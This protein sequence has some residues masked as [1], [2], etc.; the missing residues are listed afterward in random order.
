MP[1]LRVLGS[2]MSI[3]RPLSPY[4]GWRFAIEERH[5]TSS[6]VAR[7]KLWDHFKSLNIQAPVRIRWIEGLYLDLIL[8]N[9][10]SRCMYVCGSFEPNEFAYLREALPEG[11]TFIDI[12]AN[13]GFYTVFAARRVGSGGAVVAV[14]PSPREYARLENN[15]AING[16]TNVKLARTALGARRGKA[17]LHVADPEHNGQNTLGDFGHAEVKAVDHVQ[18]DITQLDSLVQDSGL[19]TVDLIKMDVEG[20]E[21]EVLKGGSATLERYKPTLLLEIFDAALRKQGASAHQVIDLL[22]RL[23]YSFYAFSEST[24]LPQAVERLNGES[25]NVLAVHR[26]RSRH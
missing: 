23:G 15:V 3:T 12:G 22:R 4:P 21:L 19:S 8:G 24:G 13:E 6:L 25:H 7:Q 20:A 16:L 11:G 17:V 9:D 5:P 1:I 2:W 14:E 18:V 10:Q 26:S